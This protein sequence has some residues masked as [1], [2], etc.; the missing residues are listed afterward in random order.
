MTRSSIL[1]TGSLLMLLVGLSTADILL[2]EGMPTRTPTDSALVP[3]PEPPT[4]NPSSA[5]NASQGSQ[6]IAGGVQKLGEKDIATTATSLGLTTQANTERTLIAGVQQPGDHM[7][8]LALL[9]DSDRAGMIAWLD[10]P[11]VKIAFLALKESLHTLFSPRV[12]DL[13][14]EN[15]RPL[16]KPP[17]NFLTFLDPELSEERFVLVRIRERL[18]EVHITRGKEDKMYKLVEALSE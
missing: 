1:L 4:Q 9:Q 17:R 15:Q 11:R 10:S 6:P 14:D 18:F 3:L 7:H 2:V 8:A 5:Q 16:G 13:L 12:Q